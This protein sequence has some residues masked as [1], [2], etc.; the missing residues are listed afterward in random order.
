MILVQLCQISKLSKKGIYQFTTDVTYIGNIFNAMG[1]PQH[2]LLDHL[3]SLLKL[4]CSQFKKYLAHKVGADPVLLA[5][6]KL[7]NKVYNLIHVE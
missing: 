7:D 3:M 2:P 1:L 6:Q 5:L 4:D